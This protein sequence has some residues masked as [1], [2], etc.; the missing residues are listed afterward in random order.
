MPEPIQVFSFG[1]GTSPDF[2]IVGQSQDDEAD[3]PLPVVITPMESTQEPS[4][5]KDAE[6]EVEVQS[7]VAK[8]PRPRRE[9]SKQQGN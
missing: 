9:N 1:L 3:Q 4:A 8:A 6:P 2:T 7:G 5:E